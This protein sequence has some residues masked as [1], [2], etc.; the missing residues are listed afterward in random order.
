[1]SDPVQIPLRAKYRRGQSGPSFPRKGAGNSTVKRASQA[2]LPVAVATE[3]KRAAQQA[4]AANR[5]ALVLDG[6]KRRWVRA[7]ALG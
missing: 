7:D 1:M 2:P 3:V 4:T 5:M 6:A